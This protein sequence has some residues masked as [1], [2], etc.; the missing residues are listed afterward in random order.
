MRSPG[1][2]KIAGVGGA[3]A[4]QL[5][6]EGL[7]QSGDAAAAN[8]L[9]ALA[10]SGA[11]GERLVLS[12][13]H[14][15][16]VVERGAEVGAL[17]VEAAASKSLPKAHALS[18]ERVGRLRAAGF[19]LPRDGGRSLCRAL[20]PT[21]LEGGAA[22]LANS[23]MALFDAVYGEA[24]SGAL[25]LERRPPGPMDLQN[26]DLIEAMT[27]AARAKDPAIARGRLYS[28]VLAATLLLLVDE[29]GAPVEVDSLQGWPV[30]AAFTDWAALRRLDPRGPRYAREPSRV[31]FPRLANLRLGS[32]LINPAGPTGGELYRNEVQT[33]AG[34]VY[35]VAPRA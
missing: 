33:I 34:A 13:G 5:Y 2:G 20:A 1:L 9:D 6:G 27:Q 10:V 15:W 25:R 26:P 16:F 24:A 19:A 12:R 23:L 3:M 29:D 11:P 21:E 14:A 8:A 28:A 35:R 18:P 30:F 4:E 22:P 7:V 32:V 17:R 31:L